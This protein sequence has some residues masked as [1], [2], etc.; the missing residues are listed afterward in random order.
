MTDVSDR[1]GRFS[2]RLSEPLLTPGEAA[3]LLSVRIS[4]IYSAVREGKLPCVRLGRHIRFVRS[5]L[6]R[7][8][9]AQHSA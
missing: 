2:H 7:W 6:E 3:E 5:E 4:W 1:D 9:L 8:V